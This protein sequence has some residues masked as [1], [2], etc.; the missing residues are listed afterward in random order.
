MDKENSNN[1][2]MDNVK[3]KKVKTNRTS[4]KEVTI[5]PI[6][7]DVEGKFM[8]VRVG[9]PEVPATDDQIEDVEK[10]LLNLFNKNNV[11]CLTF[12]THHAVTI[13]IIGEGADGRE[14]SL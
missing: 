4:K 1:G 8:L 10:R 7:Y 14:T 12:V 2:T 6:F 5:S 9:S 11:N 13:D 3:P